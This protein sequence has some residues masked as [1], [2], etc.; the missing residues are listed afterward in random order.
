M[1]IP[2][3]LDVRDALV[4]VEE[5]DFPLA[6]AG[7]SAARALPASTPLRSD[8]SDAIAA[9]KNPLRWGNGVEFMPPA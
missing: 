7:A 6:M 1:I 3:H 9:D 4:A 2:I 5:F 8:A